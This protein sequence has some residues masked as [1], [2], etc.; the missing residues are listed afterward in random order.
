MAPTPTEL[1]HRAPRLWEMLHE[2]DVAHLLWA[3]ERDV[4]GGGGAR[5]SV[6][7]LDKLLDVGH[8]L[9]LPLGRAAAV[10]MQAMRQADE[11]GSSK[12]PLLND[13]MCT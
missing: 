2:A 8:T 1:E 11:S 12:H 9:Q 10:F 4:V 6:P 5:I 7:A 3:I 13:I